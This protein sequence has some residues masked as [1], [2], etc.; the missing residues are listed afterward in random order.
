[1]LQTKNLLFKIKPHS[2][3]EKNCL[4]V[5]TYMIARDLEDLLL[6]ELVILG[7]RDLNN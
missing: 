4:N 2:A 6:C 5:L 1:M 7:A 3:L